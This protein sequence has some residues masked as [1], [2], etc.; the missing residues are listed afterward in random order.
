[1]PDP[2]ARVTYVTRFV[3]SYRWPVLRALNKRLEGGLTVA[4]GQPPAGSSLRSLTD[5]ATDV[6]RIPLTNRWFRGESL[7][8]Q[9]AGPIF[10]P[11]PGPDVLL[12][13]E[14]PR[15]L[16]LRPLLR[17]AHKRGIPVALWGHFSSIERGVRADSWKD[18][19]RLDT[20]RRADAVVAYTDELALALRP[21]LANTPVFAARNTLDTDT[22]FPLGD[23]LMGEGR[24]AIRQRLGLPA[25]RTV[26]FLG[27]LIP[28]KGVLR[29]VDIVRDVM[30]KTGEPLSLVVVGDGPE[31]AE[32]EKTAEAAGIPLRVTGSITDAAASAP[33]IAAADV[34]VNPGY[35]GLSVNHAFALG[36]PVVA[37]A[38][39]LDGTGHSP[40]WVYLRSGHNGVLTPSGSAEDL[41]AGVQ[42]VLQD[43][44]GFSRRAA[45][46]AREHLSLSRMVDGL[47]ETVTYL[48]GRP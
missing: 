46:F 2:A 32:L 20:A 30:R 5:D 1:M 18:R 37:P 27:R 6:N 33:W 39:G 31:R 38:P 14:S 42:T 13:E 44:E 8:W 3:P 22:L 15:T 10:R 40:E 26:L 11:N 28:A 43:A 48:A 7:H 23:Q 24:P 25:M 29:L 36:V 12:V 45:A 19:F 21:H 9:S 16:S 41:A 17:S 34:L 47:M 4:S 35:L